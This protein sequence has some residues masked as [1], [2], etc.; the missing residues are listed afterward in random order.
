MLIVSKIERK[1]GSRVTIGG[2]E[3]L[4]EPRGP[5]GEH[6]AEVENRDHIE[7]FLSVP[8]G[9]APYDPEEAKEIMPHPTP[10][11]RLEDGVEPDEGDEDGENEGEDDPESTLENRIEPDQDD[12]LEE[13]SDLDLSHAYKDE[14]DAAPRKNMK[15]ET[16]VRHIRKARAKAD[17]G[18]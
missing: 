11:Q 9:F 18:E 5:K 17:T 15:R 12:G 14:F 2:S 4:F 1:G 10:E 6:V 16:I 13:M 7:R 8:E 3:Y